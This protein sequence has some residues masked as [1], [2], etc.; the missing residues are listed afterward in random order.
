MKRAVLLL[1]LAACKRELSAETAEAA[2]LYPDVFSLYAGEQ[3][4]YRGC[5]PS[6]GVCHNA[7]EYPNLDSLGSIVDNIGRD[8]NLKRTDPL[9]VHDLCERPGDTLSSGAEAAEIAWIEQVDAVTRTWRIRLREPLDPGGE[10]TL[11]RGE[12]FYYEL[13]EA[14]A[15]AVVDDEDPSGKTLL[16]LAPPP[17]VED[18]EEYDEVGLLLASAGSPGDPAAIRVGDPNRN[19]TFGGELEG[20]L[21]KPGD[22]AR[23]YLIARLTDPAAGPLMPRANC[24]SWSK[25]ALRA[26]YCWVEGLKPDGSNAMAPIDYASCGAGPSVELLYPEPGPGCESS[27]L[28]PVEVADTGD[29]EATFHNVYRTVL[30][31]SCSGSMCHSSGPQSGVDFSTEN[32]AYQ[33]LGPRVIPGNPE[34]SV[35]F[36]RISPDLCQEPCETM[37]L[38]RDPLPEDKRELIRAWIAAGASR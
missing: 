9:T 25:P 38:G 14:G 10:L 31:P 4:V 7:N 12:A 36:V 33:T 26:L 1:L 13:G 16:L 32:L 17:F 30:V 19:G 21:I 28:C 37:P 18:G 29:G 11:L 15:S 8:C 3:G 20:K 35:L 5:G 6:G 34:E 23:S 27:G 24:C 2:R 22:P